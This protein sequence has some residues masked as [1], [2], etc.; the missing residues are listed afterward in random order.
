[1]LIQ[2]ESAHALPQTLELLIRRLLHIILRERPHA[3]LRPAYQQTLDPIHSAAPFLP[4][5][6]Y[7][8]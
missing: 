1:M 7:I 2:L 3:R 6:N 4:L 8:P 5:D